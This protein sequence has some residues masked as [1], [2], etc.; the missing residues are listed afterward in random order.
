MVKANDETRSPKSRL[1]RRQMIKLAGGT[2]GFTFL[3]LKSMAAPIALDRFIDAIALEQ[4]ADRD[5]SLRLPI[6]IDMQTHVWWRAATATG[7]PTMLDRAPASDFRK[8]SPR[9]DIFAMPPRT[10]SP[11]LDELAYVFVN[12][13]G[14]L[15]NDPVR[16]VRHSLDR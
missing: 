11:S 12:Q 1:S 8:A 9:A 3:Q 5:P 10:R 16:S 13:C 15:V 4:V 2:A 6:L 14:L 7:L